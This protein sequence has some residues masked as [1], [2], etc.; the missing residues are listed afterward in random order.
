[1]RVQITHLKAPWPCG[2]VVGD[3]LELPVVPVW[4]V[5]KCVTVGDDVEPTIGVPSI[6]EGGDT[7]TGDGSG[8][9]LPP[10]DSTVKAAKGKK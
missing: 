9:V 3:V 2:A 4:A 7:A 6:D 1:M 8:E 5:G 10:I